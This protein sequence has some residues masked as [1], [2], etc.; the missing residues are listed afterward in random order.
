MADENKKEEG[1]KKPEGKKGGPPMKWLIIG[2]AAV[3]ILGGGGFFFLKRGHSEEKEEAKEEH[4]T[5]KKEP[6]SEKPHE[7]PREKSAEKPG[8][9]FDLDP[10]TVNLADHP[11][12]RYLKMTIK[13]ELTDASLADKVTEHMAQIRD[14]LL[15]LLS[16]KEYAEIRTM[17][18]KMELRDE[19]LR[20]LNSILGEKKVKAVYF[21]DLVAQ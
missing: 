2:V 13:L 9:I 6:G 18:G 17:E 15:I 7:K 1:D 20:R 8:P 3:L 4:S 5:P 12:I 19:I 21:T 11:E 16:S 10:F 14:S